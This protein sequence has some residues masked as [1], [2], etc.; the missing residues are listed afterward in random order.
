[1]LKFFR[2]PFATTGDKTAVPDAVDSNGNVSYSQGYG[3]DYQRQKTD[4]AAK[5]IER[6]KMNQI[7]FDITT[8]IAEIQS[9][10]GADFITSALNGGTAYSYSQ[11]AI[12]NYGDAWYISLVAANTALPTDATKWALLPTP[13]LLQQA[14]FMSA[15]AGG[16]V[17][18]ITAA[19]SPAIAAL[20]AAPGTLSVFVRAGGANVTTI[21]TFKADTTAAK[22][23]VKGNNVPLVAGDIAGAGHWLELQ[24]DATLDKWVLQNPATGVI[25]RGRQVFTGSGTFTVPAGVTTVYLTG[26]GGGGGGGGGNSGT[27]G[28]GGG[29]SGAVVIKQAVTVTPGASISVTIGT[30]GGGGASGVA[31]SSGGT[32]SFGALLSLTGGTGGTPAGGG[33]SGGTV[34]GGTGGL[35]YP[36]QPG[37]QYNSYGSATGGNGGSTPFGSGGAGGFGTISARSGYGFGAGGGGAPSS[38]NGG[39]DGVFGFLMV[40]W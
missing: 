36:G 15:N 10:G 32:T 30:N 24:Y 13:A 4:P 18:A 17:D 5:N 37:T 20:P 1:M 28:G 23:I 35:A 7:L 2:L 19:F 14:A 25:P 38:G 40:E 22:T 6:D 34:T 27:N 12:V 39:A 3:F 33:G 21:P 26:T 9:K 8:A 31:G 11:N 29:G 16:T